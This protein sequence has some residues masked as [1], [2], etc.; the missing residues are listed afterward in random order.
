MTVIPTDLVETLRK[1]RTAVCFTGAGVS[2]ESGVPTFRGAQGGFW[3]QY[4]P[5]DLATPEGFQRNPKLVW[6]WYAWRREQLLQVQPNPGHLALAAFQNVFSDVTIVT[7]NIDGLHQRAGS[8]HVLELHGSL[9]RTKCS[10]ENRVV[11]CWEETNTAPPRCPHCGAYLRPDV[12]W[13]G[14]VLPTDVMDEAM[15]ASR[16]CDVFFA[17]GTSSLVYPAASLPYEALAA[18]ATLIEINPEPTPLSE[19][20]RHVLRASSGEVLPQ[21]LQAI[22]QRGDYP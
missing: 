22:E 5:E 14:E 16:K 10:A 6:E 8:R 12:V 19:E 4:R 2:A 1:A 18:D 7:Q 15:Q 11:E 20:A 13:F 3:Q 9:A 21:L 17:I